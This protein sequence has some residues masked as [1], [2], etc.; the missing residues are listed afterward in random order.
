[1]TEVTVPISNVFKTVQDVQ[2]QCNFIELVLPG[3]LKSISAVGDKDNHKNEGIFDRMTS[4]EFLAHKDELGK[5]TFKLDNGGT[6]T[7]WINGE[8]IKVSFT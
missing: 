8:I 4:D 5:L 3:K 6:N 2:N 1:M 7:A